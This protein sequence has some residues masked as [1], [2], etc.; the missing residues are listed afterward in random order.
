M[1]GEAFYQGA[2]HQL[3]ELTVPDFKFLTNDDS[4][5]KY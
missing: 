2:L 3:A 1:Q 4:P 5:E